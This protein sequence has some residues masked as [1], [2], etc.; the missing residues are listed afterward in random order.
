[1]AGRQGPGRV[2][3]NGH[4]HSLSMGQ[5]QWPLS[6]PS[7]SYSH[8]SPAHGRTRS[9]GA[10]LRGHSLATVSQSPLHV[11]SSAGSS[12]QQ[13]L[14]GAGGGAAAAEGGRASEASSTGQWADQ[15]GGAQGPAAAQRG[16]V[17][18]C[19]SFAEALAMCAQRHSGAM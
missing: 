12:S 11:V 1:M 7:M 17:R 10:A 4:G 16:A 18:P 19:A 13:W 9:H 5:M 3:L 2:S 8:Y 14:D 6:S 15:G